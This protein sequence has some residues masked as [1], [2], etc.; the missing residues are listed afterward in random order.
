MS[1]IM[2]KAER[3]DHIVVGAGGWVT[4]NRLSTDADMCVLPLETGQM[5]AN[6]S[7]A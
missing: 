1:S 5:T 3:F 2:T 7:M 6:A 4:A